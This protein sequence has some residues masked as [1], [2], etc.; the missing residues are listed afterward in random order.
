V[1]FLASRTDIKTLRAEISDD[2]DFDAVWDRNAERATD[3]L[4]VFQGIKVRDEVSISYDDGLWGNFGWEIQDFINDTILPW[5]IQ[6][7]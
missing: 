3:D 6:K 4:M 5:M 1:D 2:G 7:V